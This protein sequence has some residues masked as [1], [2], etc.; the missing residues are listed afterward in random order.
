MLRRISRFIALCLLITPL[1]AACASQSGADTAKFNP[2]FTSAQA[3]A[4]AQSS[5]VAA[6]DA[7]AKAQKSAKTDS[8]KANAVTTAMPDSWKALWDRMAA[9]LNAA[10]PGLNHS[11]ASQNQ[12]FWDRVY[13]RY[14]E[15]KS[16]SSLDHDQLATAQ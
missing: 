12:S 9:K 13:Q 15:L 1:L 5:A 11:A 7:L 10:R 14:R 6:A 3:G 2:M 16:S 4:F 8:A